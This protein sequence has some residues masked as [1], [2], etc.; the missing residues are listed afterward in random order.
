M[1][2]FT[3]PQPR[4]DLILGSLLDRAEAFCATSPPVDAVSREVSWPRSPGGAP[5]GA[6]R[7]RFGFGRLVNNC[8]GLLSFQLSD[9]ADDPRQHGRGHSRSSVISAGMK[10]SERQSAPAENK[11]HDPKAALKIMTGTAR[12]IT[13]KGPP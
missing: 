4:N 1:I 11:E 8:D 5:S 7:I 2:R 3:P 6:F 13:E 10:R 12:A 9:R